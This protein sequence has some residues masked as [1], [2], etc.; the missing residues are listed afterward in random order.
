MP[1][2]ISTRSL[3]V[4]VNARPYWEA[5]ALPTRLF[6]LPNNVISTIGTHKCSLYLKPVSHTIIAEVWWAKF[7]GTC[8]IML[9][10]FFITVG[11]QVII[12]VPVWCIVVCSNKL[13]K[14]NFLPLIRSRVLNYSYI[15]MKYIVIQYNIVIQYMM[16]YYRD[17]AF[18]FFF[19][20]NIS[21]STLKGV[22][23]F[24]KLVWTESFYTSNFPPIFRLCIQLTTVNSNLEINKSSNLFNC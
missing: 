18:P 21:V 19:A 12:Y 24:A 23:I 16:N 22:Q 4:G 7:R 20:I 14:T 9:P 15:Y 17:A 5:S 8:R 11:I 1:C 2:L 13:G 10:T 6:T 3:W